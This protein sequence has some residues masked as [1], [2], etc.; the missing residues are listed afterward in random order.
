MS[1]VGIALYGGPLIERGAGSEIRNA[2]AVWIVQLVSGA[3]T[4]VAVML[5]QWIRWRRVGRVFIAIAG[6][7][8]L[9]GLAFFSNFGWRAWLTFV[10]PGPL[11]IALSRF[12]GPLP[13]PAS[14]SATRRSP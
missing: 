7:V 5:A 2:Q 10:L 1:L 11:L 3:S 14:Q 8:L 9:G 4:L 12:I 6:L 13:P